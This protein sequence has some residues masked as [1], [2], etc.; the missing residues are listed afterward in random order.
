ME[1]RSPKIEVL[2]DPAAAINEEH[3]RFERAVCGA[4]SDHHAI[5]AGELSIEAK[6]RCPHGSCRRGSKENFK[7][8]FRTAQACMRAASSL[9]KCAHAASRQWV[10]SQ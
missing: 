5:R 4:A 8:S 10:P 6:A 9:R 3:R 7:G 2:A 1:T